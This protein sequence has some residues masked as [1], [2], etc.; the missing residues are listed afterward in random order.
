[1]LAKYKSAPLGGRFADGADKPGGDDPLQSIIA[2]AYNKTYS[3]WQ[4]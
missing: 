3:D 2:S 1:M 4:M